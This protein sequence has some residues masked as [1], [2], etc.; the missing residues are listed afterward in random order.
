MCFVYT[1]TYQQCK[2]FT[3]VLVIRRHRDV[4]AIFP[5]E[6]DT[7]AVRASDRRFQSK[8]FPDIR[9]SIEREV[10]LAVGVNYVN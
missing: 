5:A 4:P 2:Y 3:L 7:A 6:S 8:N 9:K 1:L 10:G